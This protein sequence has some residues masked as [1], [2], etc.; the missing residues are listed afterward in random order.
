MI[1]RLQESTEGRADLVSL[2]E[3]EKGLEQYEHANDA[4]WVPRIGLFA[5]YQYYNNLN[6]QFGDT[7]SFREAYS[8]GI[9]LTWNFFDGFASTAKA[10]QSTEQRYQAERALRM[11]QLQS[12]QDLQYWKRKYLYFVNVYRS[13]LSDIEKSKES[14]RLAREGRRVGARTNTDFLDAEAELYRAQAGAVNAQIGSI[15]A[16]IN[17]EL[18]TGQQLADLK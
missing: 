11:A 8:V 17:L 6:D 13:R 12:K 14:V 5:N 2:Q 15:E 18:A 10:H 9:S 1:S 16:L 4:H 3:K 7:S